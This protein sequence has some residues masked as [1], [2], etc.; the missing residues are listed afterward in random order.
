[1]ARLVALALAG[2]AALLIVAPASAASRTG[3]VTDGPARF[4]VLSPTLIRLECSTDRDHENTRTLTVTS[5]RARTRFTTSVSR[6]T[7]GICAA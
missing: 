5:R 3:S 7:R 1:M 4:Q 6:G 2:L